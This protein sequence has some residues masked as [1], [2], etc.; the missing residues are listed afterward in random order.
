METLNFDKGKWEVWL[1]AKGLAPRTIE[2]YGKYYDKFDFTRFEQEYINAFIGKYN[3]QVAKAFLKNLFHYIR[4]TYPQEMKGLLLE[5]EIPIVTGHIKT[6]IPKVISFEDVKKLEDA[7]TNERNKLMVLVSFFGCLRLSE[8]LGI[9]PYSFYWDIWLQNPDKK[10]K[11]KVLGKGSR[12][13]IVFIPQFL[14]AR[15]YQWIRGEVTL[16]QSKDMPLFS[17]KEVR[18]QD[19]LAKAGDKAL[20]RHINPHLLRHS[21]ATWLLEN[22]FTLEEIRDYLGHSSIITTQIYAHI[23]KE[24]LSDKFSKMT[25]F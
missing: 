14:M 17:I 19:I 25:N 9:L 4:I 22:G 16:K 23:N 12:E 21:G 24:K 20:G 13:R 6:K 1:E 7:M 18:W 3:N 11:L 8:L 10:G 2:E 15:L 5:L